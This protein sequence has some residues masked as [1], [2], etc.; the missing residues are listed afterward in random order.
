MKHNESPTGVDV[1]KTL[2]WIAG[3]ALLTTLLDA[4]M[5]KLLGV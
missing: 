5:R 2:G 4:S 1:G 3:I